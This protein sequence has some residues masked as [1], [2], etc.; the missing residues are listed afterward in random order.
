MIR[1]TVA[2]A[3]AVLVGALI[4]LSVIGTF[5]ELHGVAWWAPAVLLVVPAL[6]L[7]AFLL[8]RFR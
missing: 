5:A 6:M 3:G 8:E 7:G 2:L 1:A 4:W